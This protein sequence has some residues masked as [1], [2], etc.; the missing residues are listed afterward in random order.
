M[1]TLHPGHASRARP[2]HTSFARELSL[3]RPFHP[4]QRHTSQDYFILSCF[5]GGVAM[6]FSIVSSTASK[7]S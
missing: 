3:K 5:F 1:V 6:I 7:M 2:R 4:K